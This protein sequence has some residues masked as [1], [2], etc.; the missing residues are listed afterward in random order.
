MC[1]ATAKGISLHCLDVLFFFFCYFVPNSF[2]EIFCV[3]VS[4]FFSFRLP[5]FFVSFGPA[6]I[7]YGQCFL[8]IVVLLL[9]GCDSCIRACGI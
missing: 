1:Y 2:Y 7:G 5:S 3:L 6:G 8:F 9:R 4:L